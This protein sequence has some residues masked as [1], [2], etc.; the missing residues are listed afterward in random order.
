MTTPITLDVHLDDAA[1]DHELRADVQAGLTDT[2]R[3]LSPRWFYDAVG[4]CLFERITELPE[5]Y[6]YRSETEI[7]TRRAA[8]VAALAGPSVV[9]ELGSG[10]STKTRLLLDA[11]NDAGHLRGIVTLDVSPEALRD[12]GMHLQGRY[13]DA[14][15]HAIVGDYTRHLPV[16]PEAPD[17]TRRLLVFL[18]STIGNLTPE[19]R[20]AFLAQCAQA[21]RPGEHFLLGTDL[22]KSPTILQPAYD[23]AE[24]VTAEFNRNVL[25]VIRRRLNADVVPAD[26]AHEAWWDAENQWVQVALR[27]LRP[28]RVT[29]PGLV[30]ASFAE[31][32][33][34]LTE[35][36][37]K[38]TPERIDHELSAAGFETTHRW[39]DAAEGFAVTLATRRGVR[40]ASE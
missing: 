29:V 22:V 24:G 1:L 18:G 8:E 17:G 4:S 10:Y 27:A 20:A 13:P 15:L 3:W 6:L 2:P 9:V 26:F 33:R 30:D 34:I 12:A 31:G 5:Y 40:P 25:H 23:D 37:S 7:L 38:F 19:E 28:T 35:I 32:D 11:L 14:P 21:L 39:L 16:V 36:S